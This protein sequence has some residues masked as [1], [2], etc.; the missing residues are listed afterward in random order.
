[1]NDHI[2][3]KEGLIPAPRFKDVSFE[4]SDVGVTCKNEG[5]LIEQAR[6]RIRE[7]LIRYMQEVNPDYPLSGKILD[8]LA[9]G[10]PVEKPLDEAKIYVVDDEPAIRRA[11]QRPLSRHFKNISV[12]D[13]GEDVLQTM[14]QDDHLVEVPHLVLSDTNMKRVSG[15]E[16]ARRL[17]AV[18]A[19]I[20]PR[21]VAVTGAFLE[22]NI[23][24]YVE[25]GLPV[26]EKPFSFGVVL[27]TM[28]QELRQHPAYRS[29]DGSSQK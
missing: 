10:N 2:H 23:Q 14:F 6:T 24:S 3:P 15:P 26:I 1:M 29:A 27:A 4:I 21:F 20:R 28:A 5:P 7:L 12:F 11:I 9:T 18:D 25:N 8:G 16:L 17:Q 19:S 22:N 13:D